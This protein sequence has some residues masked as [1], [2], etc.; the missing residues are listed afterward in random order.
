MPII[1][2]LLA[3]ALALGS[4]NTPPPPSPVPK[5]DAPQRVQSRTGLF[6]FVA[7]AG[8]LVQHREGAPPIVMLSKGQ[9]HIAI[10]FSPSS[11]EKWT[12]ENLMA[13]QD[14]ASRQSFAGFVPVEKR[15]VSSPGG[16]SA[17][18]VYG[19]PGASAAPPYPFTG[20]VII[21][22]GGVGVLGVANDRETFTAVEAVIK[23][24]RAVAKPR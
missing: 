4:V 24:V 19:L 16:P 6:E 11:P 1:A 10:T 2:S 13:A 3:A 21:P 14:E 5:P 23:S 22:A 7:P 8:W 15:P 17:F 18:W 12:V 9:E 20:C